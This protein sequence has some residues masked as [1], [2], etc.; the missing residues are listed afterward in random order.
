MVDDSG[1]A[2]CIEADSGEEVW[3][4][5]L[6][7]NF[8]ASPIYANGRIYFFD[9]DGKATVIAASRDYEV[10]AENTLDEGF[11]ASPAVSGDDLFLR[12]RT[13]LYRIAAAK[14]GD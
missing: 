12:T 5:R 11:M 2:A 6:G 3:R 14:T 7:G 13:H 9:E 1:V 4:K 8:S 10:L